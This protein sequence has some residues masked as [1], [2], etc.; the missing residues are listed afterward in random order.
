MSSKS[1]I[2]SFFGA[3]RQYAVVGASR[4]PTKFGFKILSWYISHNLPVVPINPKE[5]VILGKTVVSNVTE[6]LSKFSAKQKIDG[7]DFSQ[8]D[9]LSISFLTP[10]AITTQTLEAISS[11]QDYKLVI[12]G[13]WL[14]P[15]SF[16]QQVLDK[17]E[18]IGL[19]EVTIE[20]D[21]CI[22]VRG[23]EGM[24]RANL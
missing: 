4:N 15:G 17:V 14:Q 2:R 13:I 6:L 18:A 12:K 3:S 23:E 24:Y 10:P 20:E 19:S 11:F 21:E 9:G 8:K 5:E 7:H 16:D 1:R 22:L